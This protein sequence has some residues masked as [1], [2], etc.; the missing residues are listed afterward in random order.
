[1]GLG[2]ALPHPTMVFKLPDNAGQPT[3][4]EGKTYFSHTD[5]MADDSWREE[6]A[7]G[8][9]I[10]RDRDKVLVILSK[11]RAKWDGHLGTFTA[12]SHR[13]EL[14]PDTRPVHCQPYRAGPNA[15]QAD[16]TEVER[17]LRSV[18]I[19]PTTSEWASPVVLVPKPDGSLR[20]CIDYHKLNAITVRDTYL[21]PG[22]DE[23]IESLGDAVVFSTLD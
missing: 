1:M 17:M 22:V 12:T 3:A 21:L 11:H 5:D 16:T 19:E 10:D 18:V 9:L 7:L 23:F 20:F 15:L 8:H 13:I 4:P 6:V 14:V 2:F